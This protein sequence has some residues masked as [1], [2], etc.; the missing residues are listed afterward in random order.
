M[1]AIRL[2]QQNVLQWQKNDEF[3]FWPIHDVRPFHKCVNSKHTYIY[4]VPTMKISDQGKPK[5]KWKKKSEEKET[6]WDAVHRI[7]SNNCKLFFF[8]FMLLFCLTAAQP[9]NTFI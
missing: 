6:A 8:L 9:W 5:M 1:S 7:N 2:G 4:I 3:L